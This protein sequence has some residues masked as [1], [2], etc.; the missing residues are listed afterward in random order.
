MSDRISVCIPTYNRP[1]H[2]EEALTSAL[3]QNSPPFEVV[4]GDDSPN[5]L[6]RQVVRRYKHNGARIQYSHNEPSLGVLQ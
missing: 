2:F 1:D 6:T 3:N 4:V 5:N